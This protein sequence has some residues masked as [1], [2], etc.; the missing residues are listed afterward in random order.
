MTNHRENGTI[1][2]KQ[3]EWEEKRIKGKEAG[4]PEAYTT[5]SHIPIK[6]V[7][8]PVDMDNLDYLQE[9]NFPGEYPYTRGIFPQMYREKPYVVT[10]YAGYGT[11]EETNKW[12]KYLLAQ[13][14]NR[15]AI[16]FDLPTQVGLDSDHPMAKGEVGK[17]GVA[18]DSLQD[19]EAVFD[20]IPFKGKMIT[21]NANS[22]APIIVA[23]FIAVAEKQGLSM[24]EYATG[25]QNDVLK[26][27]IARGTYIFPPKPS[28]KLCCD[29]IEFC[30][31]NGL[32]NW[33]PINISGAHIRA[34]GSNVTQELGFTLANA[35]C[36][37]E[38]LLRRGMPIDDFARVLALFF[39]SHI[40]LF[41]EACKFRAVRRMW[42]KIMKERFGVQKPE[43]T[44]L[45][46]VSYTAG[47]RLTAQQPLNNIVRV[48]IELLAA[49][50]GGVQSA[51]AS[52]YD[53]ALAIP[54]D[55]AVKVALRTQQILM[56]ETNILKTADPLGGSYFVEALTREIEKGAF[57]YIE[58][59]DKMGGAIE[60]I[61]NG[62]IQKEISE[63]SFKQQREVE[64]GERIVVGVNQFKSEQEEDIRLHQS[65][66]KGVKI[67]KEKLRRLRQQRDNQKLKG[68]LNSLRKSA[69]QGENLMPILIDA[70]KA[71]ATV[72]EICGVLKE[73]YGEYKESRVFI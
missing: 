2:E 36:Y 21:A 73:V 57:E 34:A 66:A 17:I 25:V 46:L 43:S 26:E 31:K 16:A 67:Q 41:E 71:Y 49:L 29:I 53:E 23:M 5:L 45:Y 9:L 56:H 35:I 7:Y 19:M 59:I 69:E 24:S 39:G 12:Y 38:E 28:V 10:Q 4:K 65:N 22:V 55:E 40:D 64:T 20:G 47:V 62:Y 50:L 32:H 54:S 8:T 18:I 48:T 6:N 11:A 1:R 70:V 61:E 44:A 68:V 15:L 51:V 58:K 27:F 63:E 60:A 42:A 3:R 14:T 30:A 13:G 52:S 33:L 72:G 37:I